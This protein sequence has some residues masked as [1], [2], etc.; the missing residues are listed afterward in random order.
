[1]KRHLPMN[2]DLFIFIKSTRILDDEDPARRSWHHALMKYR[3][4]SI[5]AKS[6]SL[7]LRA[8]KKQ[9]PNAH[10]TKKVIRPSRAP[11]RRYSRV[12][13]ARR[14]DGF[15]MTVAAAAAAAVVRRNPNGFSQ[16]RVRR[17]R[18]RAICVIIL[19]R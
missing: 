7:D 10:H 9:K 19:V 11:I 2:L 4:D 1:M 12:A 6:T 13:A 18:E 3:R 15:V 5:S 14:V 17:D 8:C 16:F